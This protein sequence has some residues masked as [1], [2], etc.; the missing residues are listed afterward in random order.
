MIDIAQ[1]S[2]SQNLAD[3][4]RAIACERRRAGKPPRAVERL[5][6]SARERAQGRPGIYRMTFR[7]PR[8]LDDYVVLHDDGSATVVRFNYHNKPRV[9][10]VAYERI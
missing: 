9:T 8:R 4:A 5:L 7:P 6:E 10:Y 3:R 1:V 2:Q